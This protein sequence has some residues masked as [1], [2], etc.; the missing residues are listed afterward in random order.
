MKTEEDLRT[1]GAAPLRG[2]EAK[3]GA[4]GAAPAP[5][6]LPDG[7]GRAGAAA[8]TIQEN[9]RNRKIKYCIASSRSKSI[10]SMKLRARQYLLRRCLL[11]NWRRRQ[12]AGASAVGG[13]GEGGPT[14]HRLLRARQRAEAGASCACACGKR[15][16]GRGA[17][18][19]AGPGQPLAAGVKRGATARGRWVARRSFAPPQSLAARSG[20]A[21]QETVPA[22]VYELGAERPNVLRASGLCLF[23]LWVCLF[24]LW[25]VLVSSAYWADMY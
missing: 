5:L 9:K 25:A 7:R 11:S 8:P 21:A 10:E 6:L 1:D 12:G 16:R 17:A 13:K 24:P 18:G 19:R 14:G 22:C 15:S 3:T 4:G 20:S 23:P 2:E